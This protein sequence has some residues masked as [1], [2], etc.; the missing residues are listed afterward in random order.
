MGGDPYRDA[1]HMGRM[2]HTDSFSRNTAS[3]PKAVPPAR[4]FSEEVAHLD[5]L[6]GRWWIHQPTPRPTFEPFGKDDP[7]RARDS[8]V[9]GLRSALCELGDRNLSL[10]STSGM[11]RV[12]S[13]LRFEDA[14]EELF[15]E[16]A[17]PTYEDLETRPKAGD[18]VE[19]IDDKTPE[20]WFAMRCTPKGSET[21]ASFMLAQ[22]L[23]RQSISEGETVAPTTL[24]LRN[25]KGKTYRLDVQWKKAA[26]NPPPCVEGDLIDPGIG[27]LRITDL[28]CAGMDGRPSPVN[29][30]QQ[31]DAALHGLGELRELVLDV[32]RASGQDLE[33]AKRLAQRLRPE[34]E[35][36][37]RH[38]ILDPG[39]PNAGFVD[40]P[41]PPPSKGPFDARLWVLQGPG[42]I[43]ACEV[44][45]AFLTQDPGIQR[46]GR[47]TGGSVGRAK[48][49]KLPFSNLELGIPNET[50]ALPGTDAPLEG[51]GIAPSVEVIPTV[52]DARTG[53]DPW[54]E[55]VRNRTLAPN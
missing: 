30:D 46:L 11:R 55:A 2:G 16:S 17:E 33:A 19:A 12:E 20:T 21:S 47:A 38:R 41:L 35:I 43:G 18:V 27:R 53:R 9:R 5:Q 34:Q 39:H 7:P 48:L 45:V 10:R 26:P 42:C 31:V 50:F 4:S 8:Y 36:W 52:E 54:L 1:V 32:R 49:F 13:G 24:T 15:L 25:A 28:D 22:A 23:T 6:L 29:F 51:H 37:L 44:F 3:T 40:E 14:G